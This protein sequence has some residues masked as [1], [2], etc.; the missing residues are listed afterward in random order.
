VSA[1]LPVD[2][3]V[4]GCPPEPRAILLGIFAALDKTP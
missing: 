2:A 3:V 4:H 1:I